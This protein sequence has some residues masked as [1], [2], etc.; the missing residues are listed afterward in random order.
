MKMHHVGN[1]EGFSCI[2]YNDQCDNENE[3]CEEANVEQNS[4]KM[5]RHQKIR[6]EMRLTRKSERDRVTKQDARKLIARLQFHSCRKALKAVLYLH[7]KSRAD[8]AMLQ[9]RERG[10]Y[11][12][13]R[14]I[15]PSLT[16]IQHLPVEYV[17]ELNVFIR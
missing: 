10:K 2:F 3:D 16:V 9:S 15:P 1:Y 8:S 11:S 14:V 5:R 12:Y 17:H 13:I 6:K 7:W 4:A